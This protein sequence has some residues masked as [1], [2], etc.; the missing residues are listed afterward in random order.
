M[1][2]LEKTIRKIDKS[3]SA[4][5]FNKERAL[6]FKDYSKEQLKLGNLGLKSNT[7]ATRKIQGTSH[8][9]LYFRGQLAKQF[10]TK[11]GDQNAAEAGYFKTNTRKPDGSKISYTAIANLQTTGYR[12]P[13]TGSKGDNVRKWLAGHGIFPSANKRFIVVRPRPHVHN[14]IDKYDERGK[15]WK[16]IEKYA[17]RVWKSL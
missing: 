7:A 16:V 6:R 14:S 13:L 12:I 3:F 5:A 4:Y 15:D 9:P 10:E 8:N 17:D 2:E 11:K 1:Y